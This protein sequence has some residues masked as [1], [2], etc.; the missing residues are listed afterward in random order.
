V[1]PP[2]LVFAGTPAFACPALDVLLRRH[3]PVAVLTQPDRPAGRGRQLRPSPVKQRAVAAGI[4]VMQPTTLREDKAFDALAALQPDL[5]VTA[6]YG[7]LL[8]KRVLA[9]PALGCWNLHASLLP[10]WRGASPIQQA[11]LAGDE[12]TGVTLMKMDAGLD[13]GD[14]ILRRSTAIEPSDTAGSLH[15]RLAAIA[16]SLLDEALDRLADGSLPDPV[17]Q[18]SSEA[19]HAPMID[20]ADA[21]LDWRADAETLAR[22]V[23]AYN[24]WPVAHGEIAGEPMR[25]FDARPIADDPGTSAPGQPVTGRGHPDRLRV[26]CGR[27][28]LEVLELQAP[29]KRRVDAGQWLNARPDWRG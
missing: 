10:R 6:A 26:A 27:G 19:T 25:V 12:E 7:L 21:E 4:P 2:R 11:I 29:G 15:D 8:P 14:M 1:N 22:R 13:T 18:R 9:L 5:I 3:P 24:P 23:R 16:A 17:A 28:Q 20:K